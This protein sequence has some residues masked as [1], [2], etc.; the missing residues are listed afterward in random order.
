MA[1]FQRKRNVNIGR[2]VTKIAVTLIALY[3]GGI[4]MTSLGTVMNGTC[5]P[6]YQGL[7]LIGWTIG[8]GACSNANPAGSSVANTVTATT[9]TGILGVVGVIGLASIVMEFVDIRM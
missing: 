3:A 1:R 5:S 7:S 8:T 2:V 4:I 9:Q 6:F